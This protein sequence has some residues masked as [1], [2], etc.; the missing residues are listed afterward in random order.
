M[1]SFLKRKRD[2]LNR[3]FGTVKQFDRYWSTTVKAEIVLWGKPYKL[4][5][6]VAMD[7]EHTA[8]TQAQEDIFIRF[9]ENSSLIRGDVERI[10]ADY[11]GT[12]DES[13]LL[14][15]FDPYQLMISPNGE[16]AII[17]SNADDED[18][19]D[20]LPGL[21]VVIYPSLAIFTEEDYSEYAL[22]DGCDEIRTILY[23]GA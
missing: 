14:K 6:M 5:C 4:N 17:A 23:G 1:F 13:V 19:H 10:V 9:T 15:K 3:A 8:I 2:L 12:T 11:F 18:M 22:R 7:S 20:V 21:A 16:C